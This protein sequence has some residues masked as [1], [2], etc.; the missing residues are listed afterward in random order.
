MQLNNAETAFTIFQLSIMLSVCPQI[1]YKLLLWNTLG[2]S[3][4]SQEHSATIVYAK[5]GGQRECIMGY[6][7]IENCMAAVAQVKWF[8]TFFTLLDSRVF[9]GFQGPV[10]YNLYSIDFYEAYTLT[11]Q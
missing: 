5:F 3:A 8:Y 11:E 10:P 9:Q 1:L 7:K 4:Y 6:W 2:R